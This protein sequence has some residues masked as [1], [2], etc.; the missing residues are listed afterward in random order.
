MSTTVHDLEKTINSGLTTNVKRSE[1]NFSQ[2]FIAVVKPELTIRSR[3]FIF[4]DIIIFLN[5]L[6]F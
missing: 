3:S 1:I 4:I 6:L 2:L 5:F